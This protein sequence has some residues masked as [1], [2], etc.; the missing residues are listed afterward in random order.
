MAP[1]IQAIKWLDL[2]KPI[3]MRSL[4]RFVSFD[5]ATPAHKVVYSGKMFD[6]DRYHAMAEYNWGI[7]FPPSIF[8]IDVPAPVVESLTPRSVVHAPLTTASTGLPS[9]STAGSSTLTAS[10]SSSSGAHRSAQSANRS[11]PCKFAL[12]LHS[13]MTY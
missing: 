10:Q 8:E 4:E 1:G 6:L 3:P 13:I 12:F 9:T 11:S 2:D 5:D 7:A